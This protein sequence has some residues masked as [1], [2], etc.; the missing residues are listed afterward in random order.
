MHE[1]T[2]ISKYWLWT[3]W[4]KNHN[5][6]SVVTHKTPIQTFT[7]KKSSNQINFLQYSHGFNFHFP[8]KLPYYCVVLKMYH[9]TKLLYST[10]H[11]DNEVQ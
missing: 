3:S 11:T 10:L 8:Y 5:L 2:V 1:V 6:Q 7:N 9:H 4:H